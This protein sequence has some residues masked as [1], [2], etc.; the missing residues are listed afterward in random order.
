MTNLYVIEYVDNDG[1]DLKAIC[2]TQEKAEA[3]MQKK[4]PNS[5]YYRIA[6]WILD[7][8]E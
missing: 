2:S 6:H 8:N 7:G 5:N 1:C 4:W 3:L